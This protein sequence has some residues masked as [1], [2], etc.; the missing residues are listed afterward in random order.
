[1]KRIYGI[2]ATEYDRMAEEQNGVCAICG[3]TPN[4]ASKKY[5]YVDHDH[6][7][8]RVRGLLCYSCNT[9]LGHFKDSVENLQ[10]AIRYLSD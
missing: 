9:A 10:K 2:D 8:N 5:L 3:G 6:T 1:M 7:T 4:G